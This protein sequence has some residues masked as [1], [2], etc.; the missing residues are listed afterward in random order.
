MLLIRGRRISGKIKT[1]RSLGSHSLNLIQICRVAN[2][3]NMQT[4]GRMDRNDGST[5][6]FSKFFSLFCISV[7]M[8]KCVRK[9][10]FVFIEVGWGIYFQAHALL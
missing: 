5:M 8:Q 7:N 10:I 2:E 9:F 3:K 4:G 1:A 6:R